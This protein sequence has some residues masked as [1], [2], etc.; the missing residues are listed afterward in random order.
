MDS[1]SRAWLTHVLGLLRDPNKQPILG[2]LALDDRQPA[3]VRATALA[4]LEVHE[5]QRQAVVRLATSADPELQRAALQALQG[6]PVSFEERQAL[7][8]TR[9]QGAE[10]ASLVARLLGEPFAGRQRP[11]SPSDIQSWRAYLH[12]L[13]GEANVANGRRVFASAKIG[14]CSTCHRLDGIGSTAGPDLTRIAS[15]IE[16]N[17]ILESI[18]QPNR[19]VAPQWETFLITTTDGQTRT[20]F[21]LAEHGGNHVYADLTGQTFE[22]RIDDIVKRDRLPTSIMPEGLVGKLTDEELRDLLAFL[23]AKR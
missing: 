13:S 5:D 8:K 21:Q 3:I 6:I 19:N 22:I 14:M 11:A 9:Q 2:R 1:E 10:F 16:P 20:A 15:Q 23:S 12:N 17:Y 18:L 7:A 4:H